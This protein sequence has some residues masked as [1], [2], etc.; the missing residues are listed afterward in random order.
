MVDPNRQAAGRK[1]GAASA[2]KYKEAHPKPIYTQAQLDEAVRSAITQATSGFPSQNV[3]DPSLASQSKSSESSSLIE[4]EAIRER[5]ADGYEMALK[6]RVYEAA[7]LMLKDIRTLLAAYEASEQERAR[8][9]KTLAGLAL[10]TEG[11]TATAWAEIE[12]LR[13]QLTSSEAWRAGQLESVLRSLIPRL[14]KYCRGEFGDRY[15]LQQWGTVKNGNVSFSHTGASSP[16]GAEIIHHA[17][18]RAGLD[19]EEVKG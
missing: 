6:G 14:C 13:A 12:S 11:V 5:Q 16:C 9:V 8:A 10:T 3:P 15:P 1:G 4:I 19:S 17:L 7:I 2:H 18:L